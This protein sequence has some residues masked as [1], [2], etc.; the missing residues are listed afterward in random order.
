M[1]IHKPPDRKAQK[2]G[3]QKRER[4][5]AREEGAAPA[6]L[7]LHRHHENS[8][9]VLGGAVRDDGG[10]PQSPDQQPAAVKASPFDPS[11][12]VVLNRSS[13]ETASWAELDAAMHQLATTWPAG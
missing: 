6:E 5:G 13:G 10:R 11:H 7:P 8:E 2:A 3:R 1:S 12:T 4:K 9:K